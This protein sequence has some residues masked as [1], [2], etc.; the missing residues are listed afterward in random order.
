MIIYGAQVSMDG[1]NIVV[2]YQSYPE[3]GQPPFDVMLGRLPTGTY[4]VKVLTVVGPITTQFTVSAPT[5]PTAPCNDVPAVNYT[6][7]WWSP[8]ESGW[9]LSVTQGPT[10]EV[11]ATW[12]VYDLSGNP[13]WY[14]MQP[15]RWTCGPQYQGPIYRTS[16]TPAAGDATFDFTQVSAVQVGTGILDFT[17]ATT[18]AF[19]YTVNGVRGFKNISRMPME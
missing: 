8:S 2:Q 19:A 14:S 17:S 9:G 6:D 3:L 13:V 7:L 15:G 11:V 1:T 10:N 12:F 18:G 5:I 16:N 4:S